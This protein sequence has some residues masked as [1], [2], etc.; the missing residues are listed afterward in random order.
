MHFGHKK[1]KNGARNACWSRQLWSSSWIK[2]THCFIEMQKE[3][4]V[5]IPWLTFYNR[6]GVREN[7]TKPQINLQA[8]GDC[9]AQKL[10]EVSPSELSKGPQTQTRRGTEN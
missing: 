1:K 6:K 3:T 4:P 8:R 2:R 9:N 7:K 10:E 5:W